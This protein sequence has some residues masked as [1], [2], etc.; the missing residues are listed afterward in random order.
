MVE[1]VEA[2]F[3]PVDRHIRQSELQ[4]E[5]R[6]VKAG[7]ELSA[8][9]DEGGWDVEAILRLIAKI[10]KKLGYT[11]LISSSAQ[12]AINLVKDS[13]WRYRSAFY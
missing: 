4:A 6:W 10:L 7:G 5:V 12:K 11:V 2:D 3:L 1:N 9:L 8:A 13:P